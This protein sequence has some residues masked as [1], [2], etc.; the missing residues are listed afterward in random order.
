MFTM[1]HAPWH[2]SYSLT[3]GVINDTLESQMYIMYVRD[4]YACRCVY[5][6][7]QYTF[8]LAAG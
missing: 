5:V 6:S 3:A 1:Y 2:V 8:I 7:Y 4:T